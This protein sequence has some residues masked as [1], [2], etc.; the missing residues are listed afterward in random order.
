MGRIIEYII[1]FLGI[2]YVYSVILVIAEASLLVLLKGLPILFL[3]IGLI[4][5]YKNSLKSIGLANLSPRMISKIEMGN[6]LFYLI[7]VALLIM[8]AGWNTWT[9]AFS[10]VFITYLLFQKNP[11]KISQPSVDHA[12]LNKIERKEWILFFIFL[13]LAYIITFG[14]IRPDA[15]DGFYLSVVTD[16]LANKKNPLLF[17]DPLHGE[18]EVPLL[19]TAAKLQT[20]EV[21]LAA[22]SYV[23]RIPPVWLYYI[24]M[25]GIFVLF[26]AFANWW[27]F[28]KILADKAIYALGLLLLILWAW[29]DGHKTFGNFS[30]VR[31]FHGKGIYVTCIA[32]LIPWFTWRF[33]KK[34][35]LWQFLLVANVVLL[36]GMFSSSS[37]LISIFSASLA[38]IGGIYAFHFSKRFLITFTLA[39]IPNLL[40]LLFVWLEDKN[41]IAVF[42]LYMNLDRNVQGVLGASE[43]RFKMVLCTLLLLSW[44]VRQSQKEWAPWM[45]GWIYMVFLFLLN[46]WTSTFLGENISGVFAWRHIWA[47]PVP[48]LLA[49]TMVLPS[50]YISL[51]R[52]NYIISL[53]FGLGLFFYAGAFKVITNAKSGS[54][55]SLAQWGGVEH[56]PEDWSSAKKIMSLT[57]KK[58]RALVPESIAVALAGIPEHPPLVGVRGFYLQILEGLWKPKEHVTKRL[59]LLDYIQKPGDSTISVKKFLK[60][61]LELEVTILAFPRN[62]SPNDVIMNNLKKMKFTQLDNEFRNIWYQPEN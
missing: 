24:I 31:I 27:V 22:I 28:R 42:N 16:T 8:G 47:V 50:Q 15:D 4:F 11:Q 37:V 30:F 7:A 32:P 25:P 61:L 3:L 59:F 33:I 49:L 20:Y 48:F 23:T 60:L 54:V 29:G 57:H 35:D 40:L 41:N 56:F 45:L 26:W 39:L 34:P 17:F 12:T 19:N 62:H 5:K 58:G 53:L 18:K 2:S 6:P 52:A 1:I 21:W 38:F 36:G 44:F 46:P 51:S 9:W 10:L 43:L 14:F 55:G 13:I